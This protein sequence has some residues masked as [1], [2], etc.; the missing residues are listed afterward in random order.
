[1]LL[2]YLLKQVVPKANPVHVVRVE[3]N[4][5]LL[6]YI[7]SIGTVAVNMIMQI[8]MKLV[9]KKYN[10]GMRFKKQYISFRPAQYFMGEW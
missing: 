2:F 3:W 7:I 1:M 8:K 9:V 6:P 10:Q 5:H 4:Y